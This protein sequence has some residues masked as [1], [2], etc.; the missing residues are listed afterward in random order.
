MRGQCRKF[1]R[2]IQELDT[3]RRVHGGRL[4]EGSDQQASSD[5]VG[6]SCETEKPNLLWTPEASP[7]TRSTNPDEA[8]TNY[9]QINCFWA[10]FRHL[11]WELVTSILVL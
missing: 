7:R 9:Q 4:H 5:R 3:D 2:R 10:Y 11:R 1:T 6:S 8:I